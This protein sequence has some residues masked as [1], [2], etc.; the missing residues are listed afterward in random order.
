MIK[1]YF[2]LFVRNL[3][4]QKMFSLIN[5]L[6]LTVS[7]AS[8][9]LIYL[10]VRNEFSYDQFHKDADR[11]YRVNQTFIWGESDN[12]Q[13]ASTGPGVANALKEELP[14]MELITSIHTPGNFIISYTNEKNEVVSFEE[15]RLFAADS[16]FFRMFT[17][18][19]VSGTPDRALLQ[20]NTLVMT[21]TMAKKYFGDVNPIGKM[22]R[23]TAGEGDQ[24][25]EVTGVIKDLPE[26]SYL[27]FHGLLSMTSLPIIRKLHWSWV[28]TQ[29]ET[30][31]RVARNTDIENTR[32]KLAMI[33][34]K[35]AGQSTMAAMGMTYKEYIAAGKKWELFL[36]PLTS[37]HLP[38][39]VVYNR[40]NDAG[41]IKI[42]YAMIGAALFIVLLSCINFMNL[43]TA[44]FT[45]RVKE[46][47]IR[48]IMG[49]GRGALSTMYFFEALS[50]C[51]LALIAALALIQTLLPGFNSIT[52]KALQINF[53]G[54][55][56]LMVS[57]PALIIIM[58]LL[59]GSYPAFFLTS[60]N[61]VE[62]IRGKLRSGSGGKKFRNS[63]VVFQFS[64]SIFLIVCTSV[65]FKQLNFFSEKDLG[66]NKENLL[67]LKNVKYTKNGESLSKDRK[68]VV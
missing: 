37:I 15:D 39:H 56:G 22:V 62:A 4:R 61:P 21:E 10:Y 2:L 36:Q 60:F 1:N 3:S 50:F 11:I 9:L 54:D 52:G 34:P 59:A 48:K 68:S 41:N 18:P 29:L 58:A 53:A 16:N 44:Q 30:Y 45:R 51:L 32:K 20:A 43:S 7:I 31:I 42:I 8:T 26:N 38:S 6:G 35:H 46:A 13:F 55:L 25:C 12:N 27:Q 17:F 23:L 14:E 40:L 47:G 67:V 24:T 63:L 5:L 19:F 33:P 64:V 28:W 66:F 57:L 49:L 65:V